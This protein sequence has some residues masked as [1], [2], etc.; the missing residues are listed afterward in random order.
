MFG[1]KLQIYR[2][3]MDLR[4]LKHPIYSIRHNVGKK[5]SFLVALPY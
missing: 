4:I 5:L 2:A 1:N 3:D